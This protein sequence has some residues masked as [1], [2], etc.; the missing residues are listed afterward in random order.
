ML[1]STQ[2]KEAFDNYD[3][4]KSGSLE[5]DEVVKLASSLGAKTTKKDIEE[6]FKSIDVDHDN[7]LS[8]NEFLAWY[9]VGK[10]S[11]LTTLLKYQLQMERGMKAL[12]GSLTAD[13]SNDG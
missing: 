6:L 13:D 12:G 7:C 10:H 3:K 1:S 4:D 2:L 8:F 5:I 9:R 11:K